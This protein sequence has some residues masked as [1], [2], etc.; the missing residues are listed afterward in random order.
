MPRSLCNPETMEDCDALALWYGEA[1][2]M[3]K[4][5]MP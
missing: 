2:L 4:E 1:G 5:L 3:A